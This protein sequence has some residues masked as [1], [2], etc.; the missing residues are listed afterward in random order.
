M[1]TEVYNLFQRGYSESDIARY[2][3]VPRGQITCHWR[4][5]N[6]PA[7]IQEYHR[8]T[9]ITNSNV[10]DLYRLYRARKSKEFQALWI[11]V[12][13]GKVG[14]SVSRTLLEMELAVANPIL[15]TFFREARRGNVDFNILAK[16]DKRMG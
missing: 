4:V 1:F 9:Y 10:N 6:L 2:L 12:K 3:D 13:N 16:I 8:N 15:K 7:E 14:R 11:E 5:C